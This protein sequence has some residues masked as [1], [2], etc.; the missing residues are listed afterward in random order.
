MNLSP[1]TTEVYLPSS[2][3]FPVV[4]TALLKTAGDQVAKHTPILRFKYK[5]L[6]EEPFNAENG[7]EPKHVEKEFYMTFDVPISGE[8][9]EWNVKVGQ[10]IL[11]SKYVFLKFIVL[12]LNTDF[13]VLDTPLPASKSHVPILSSSTAYVVFV[14]K[15]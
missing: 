1:P 11:N 10:E 13:N 12:L 6:V 5:N 14:A 8:L 4:T 7:E 3:L 9:S 15:Y 2:T